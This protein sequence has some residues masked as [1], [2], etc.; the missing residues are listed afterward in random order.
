MRGTMSV[1]FFLFFY[2][3]I[4]LLNTI[5]PHLKI[6][7][8]SFE[9]ELARE[10]LFSFFFW[11]YLTELSI[12]SN[13]S[14]NAQNSEAFRFLLSFQESY[15]TFLF[16]KKIKR[17]TQLSLQHLLFYLACELGLGSHY[18]C[19]SAI[20]WNSAQG[21]SKVFRGFRPLAGF[22]ALLKIYT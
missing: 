7:A 17:P 22:I 16:P 1:D 15:S 20:S 11:S 14:D 8:I 10:T 6:E 13:S 9:R 3:Q 19:V 12:S 18:G 4:N 2:W 5:L 21:P